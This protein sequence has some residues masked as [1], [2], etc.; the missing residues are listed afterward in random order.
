MKKV[1]FFFPTFGWNSYR[2]GSGSAG[3][4]DPDRDQDR[5]NDADPNESGSAAMICTGTGTLLLIE[6]RSSC[7]LVLTPLRN[8]WVFDMKQQDTELVGA[9]V[10]YL[11]NGLAFLYSRRDFSPG[12][13]SSFFMWFAAYFYALRV[14]KSIFWPSDCL[15]V[16]IHGCDFIVINYHIFKRGQ[17]FLSCLSS[18]THSFS[19]FR[20]RCGRW[21]RAA[22]TLP[23]TGTW[24]ML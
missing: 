7:K 12:F 6:N 23:P 8:M 22:M 3:D 24:E 1:C 11:M 18:Q 9:T 5:Q 10:P 20:A 15:I 19:Y 13:K 14:N 21:R 4:A 16:L 2:S 17:F